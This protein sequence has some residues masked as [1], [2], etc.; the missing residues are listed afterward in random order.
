MRRSLLM[1]LAFASCGLCSSANAAVYDAVA[2]F[3]SSSN[4]NGPWSYGSGVTGTSFTPYTN[5]GTLDVAGVSGWSDTSSS[6]AHPPY[7]GIATAGPASALTV[8][9]PNG[10]LDLHPGPSID[11]IVRWTAPTSGTFSVSGF[12]ELLDTNPTGVIGEIFKNSTPEFT[13]TLTGPGAQ[14]PNGPVGQ[15]QNFFGTVTLVAGDVLSFGV[16]NDGVYN[17]DSTGF[18]ATI[19]AVPE[20]STWAMMILGFLGVSFAAHRR[21]SNLNLRIA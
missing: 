12:F 16:N 1:F 8:F 20:P 9:V 7:V 14:Q 5:F 21:K 4:P 15:A 2:A 10:V 17:N 3:S 6:G 18:D 19:S 11:T 13:T